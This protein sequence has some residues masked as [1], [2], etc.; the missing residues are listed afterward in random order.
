MLFSATK[1]IV[2]A[3]GKFPSNGPGAWIQTDAPI[4]PGNSGGPLL[5][6]YGEVIGINTLK[7]VRKNVSG[8]G[9][10]LSASDL[11]TVLR[12]FYPNAQFAAPQQAVEVSSGKS[13][14]DPVSSQNSAEITAPPQPEGTGTVS[15]TSD[16]DGAEIYVD[17]K[18]FGDAPASLRLPVGTHSIVLKLA[19][20]AD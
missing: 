20:R 11:M 3:V 14:D 7:I 16:P 4:N 8:I 17:D 2:S 15:V 19:G 6:M 12:R 18:F 13:G 1:G 10:A 9:F 5:N